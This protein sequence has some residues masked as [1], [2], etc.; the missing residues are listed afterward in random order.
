ML[1]YRFPSTAEF[2]FLTLNFITMKKLFVVISLMWSISGKAQRI[3]D[4]Y[5]EDLYKLIQSE[6]K[7]WDWKGYDIVNDSKCNIQVI[8]KLST[9]KF[10]IEPVSKK[11]FTDMNTHIIQV[12]TFD[13]IG[14]KTGDKDVSVNA[15]VTGLFCSKE[16]AKEMKFGLIFSNDDSYLSEVCSLKGNNNFF[17]VNPKELNVIS[18]RRTRSFM[19]LIA[20]IDFNLDSCVVENCNIN[21]K[22]ER[23]CIFPMNFLFTDT[24]SFIHELTEKLFDKYNTDFNKTYYTNGIFNYMKNEDKYGNSIL[25]RLQPERDTLEILEVTNDTYKKAVLNTLEARK[26]NAISFC[27]VNN[28]ESNSLRYYVGAGKNVMTSSGIDLGYVDHFLDMYDARKRYS[29]T[30][31]ALVNYLLS[32]YQ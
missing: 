26:M 22:A 18:D 16:M 4:V 1:F 7:L 25:K 24:V 23:L 19:E 14:E 2:Y 11:T 15:H 10:A 13:S 28:P 12:P 17:I 8:K 3:H 21:G 30:S 29:K 6:I 27:F 32:V 31:N 5:Y 9:G 20:S